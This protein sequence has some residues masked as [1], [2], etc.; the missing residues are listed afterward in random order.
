MNRFYIDDLPDP[1]DVAARDHAALALDPLT[2][3]M[4]L[5]L[6]QIGDALLRAGAAAAKE[7][8]RRAAVKAAAKAE[9]LERIWRFST[10]RNRK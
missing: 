10:T 8:A 4:D 1:D 5:L 6:P 9:Q 7:D 3:A 2:V